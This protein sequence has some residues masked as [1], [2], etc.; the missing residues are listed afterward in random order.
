MLVDSI[1]LNKYRIVSIIS[2]DGSDRKGMSNLYKSVDISLGS[3]WAIKEII[4][5]E[6]G[7]VSREQVA[8]LK[9][10]RILKKLQHHNIPRIVTIENLPDRIIIVMDW[11]DGKSL[12]EW[13]RSGFGTQPARGISIAKTVCS[14]LSYLHNR[15]VPIIYRDMK[16]DNIMYD[17]VTKRVVLLDFGI[18]DEV[19]EGKPISDRLGTRGYQDAVYGIAISDR[20]RKNG[21][22]ERYYDFRTDIYSLG[23]TLFHLFTS[24]PPYNYQQ[25]KKKKNL[26][27]TR[28]IRE[29]NKNV[30]PALAEVII[31]ATSPNI[32]DRYATIEDMQLALEDISKVDSGIYGSYKKKINIVKGI[33]I[34]G[35]ALTLGSSI[36]YYLNSQNKMDLYTELSS[37]ASK[38]GS[39]DD[40]V[41]VIE[42][43]PS[44]ITPYFG[45]LDAIKNDGVFTDEEESTLLDLVNPNI[46]HLSKDERYQQLAFELGRLYWLYYKGENP[47]LV[48]SR[49]FKDAS[50][51]SDLAAVYSSI[52]S[53]S[54]EIVKA[55][56][57]GTDTG[58]YKE[59]WDLLNSVKGQS[60]LVNLQ[61]ASARLDLIEYYTFR[62]KSDGL[63]KETLISSIDSIKSMVESKQSEGGRIGELSSSLSSRLQKVQ[64]IVEEAYS[65]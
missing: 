52:G 4:K 13:I 24:I 64:A 28:D 8:I 53:F 42:Y 7:S 12:S 47:E 65:V 15:P 19:E 21:V 11:V 35:L 55:A 46:T 31:K 23:W 36:P 60:D 25:S 22:P 56:N 27:I 33:G 44:D 32:E 45:L 41:K 14:I 5:R 16:P 9:E 59:Q 26:E 37:R 3:Y 54:T 57:E 2:G 10:A 6:D 1:I 50:G 61:I 62:L 48:A 18:S 40:Y 20:E 51:Y 34:L 58:K 29:F 49:W 39:F 63:S 43:H 30:S 17:P 38:S